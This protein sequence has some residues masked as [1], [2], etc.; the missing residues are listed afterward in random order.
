M[1]SRK[2]TRDAP[3]LRKVIG[4]AIRDATFR[5]ALLD[6]HEKAISTGKRKLRFGPEKLSPKS[7]EVIKSFTPAEFDTLARIH[8]R[9]QRSGVRID[10][11][12]MF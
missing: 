3:Y 6:N 8:E 9:S 2:S 12:T 7:V 1:S 5:K 11:L 10:P 4:L